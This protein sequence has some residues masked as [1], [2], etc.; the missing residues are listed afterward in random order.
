[1][2]KFDIINI[3]Q[4]KKEIQTR[5]NEYETKVKQQIADNNKYTITNRD[6]TKQINFTFG[7]IT[8]GLYDHYIRQII[9]SIEDNNI[10]VYEI[11]IVGNSKIEPTD[12]IKIIPFDD[13]IKRGW[14]TRK[15]NI[16]TEQAQ[17][18]NVVLMHDYIV[19]DKYWYNGFLQWGDDYEWCVNRIVNY[20]RTRFRDYTAFPTYL[21]KSLSQIVGVN[22]DYYYTRCLL[23]Y[24]YENTIHTNKYMYVSGSYYIIKKHIAQQ[25]PLDETLSYAQGEDTEYSNRLHN[26]NIIIRCNP[27]S[28]VG[29]LKQKIAARWENVMDDKHLQLFINACDRI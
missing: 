18:D 12:K 17:Y 20:D 29:C 11:I 1:M 5:R 28:R 7:I 23:P 14:I 24:D 21:D 26:N 4:H 10:P 16:I 3:I 27:Y 2:R 6:T 25:H 15:K 19:F 8:S 9:T 22:D 13:T